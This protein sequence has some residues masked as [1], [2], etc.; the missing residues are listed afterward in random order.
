MVLLWAD[1]RH[2]RIPE[3]CYGCGK[4]GHTLSERF[5]VP[6]DVKEGRLE[7]LYGEWL[8]ASGSEKSFF[9]GRGGRRGGRGRGNNVASWRGRL[10]GFEWRPRSQG[11]AINAET[12]NLEAVISG[13]DGRP[14]HPRESLGGFFWNN[15]STGVETSSASSFLT[16]SMMS[17]EEDGEKRVVSL[18]RLEGLRCYLV[19]IPR[20]ARPLNPHF[21]EFSP[22][23]AVW[24]RGDPRRSAVQRG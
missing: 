8:L 22:V 24:T 14:T 9:R 5:S 11:I 2:E 19:P 1:L 12:P 17:R 21:L 15:K 18:C 4:L 3:S 23:L 16:E 13:V 6:T 10:E 20:K 7:P